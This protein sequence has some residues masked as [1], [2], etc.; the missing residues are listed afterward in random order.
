MGRLAYLLVALM[1]LAAGVAVYAL[2]QYWLQRRTS[3]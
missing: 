3:H 1:A 2:L